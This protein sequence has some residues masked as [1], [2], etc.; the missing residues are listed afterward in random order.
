MT[1]ADDDDNALGDGVADSGASAVATA[2][3]LTC[4]MCRGSLFRAPGAAADDVGT[5]AAFPN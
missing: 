2:P 3:A 5:T 1:G 4:D